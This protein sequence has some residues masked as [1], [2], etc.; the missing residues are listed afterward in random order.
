MHCIQ[1]AGTYKLKL[2]SVFGT[3]SIYHVKWLKS[4]LTYMNNAEM[5]HFFI[6][7]KYNPGE[8]VLE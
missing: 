4:V 1:W 7:L 2:L 3:L 5:E 6:A 8:G